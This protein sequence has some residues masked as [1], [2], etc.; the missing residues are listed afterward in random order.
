MSTYN[1]DDIEY[2]DIS[3]ATITGAS[4]SNH[5]HDLSSYDAS[6]HCITDVANASATTISVSNIEDYWITSNNSFNSGVVFE[7]WWPPLHEIEDMCKEYPGLAK[8][9]ENFK[10][11]Y[12]MVEQDW[13]GKKK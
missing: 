13:K 10:T 12:S 5:V 4:I 9:F 2:I 3:N 6:G 11:A 8:A 1:K 7:N